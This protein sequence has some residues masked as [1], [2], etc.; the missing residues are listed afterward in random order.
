[1]H[2]TL[3]MI[4]RI[5]CEATDDGIGSDDLYAVI[6][7][8]SIA[9]GSFSAGDRIDLGIEVSIPAG[10]SRMTVMERDF[11]DPDDALATIDLSQDMDVER[12]VGILQ[13]DARYDIWFR[14]ISGGDGIEGGGRC[15]DSCPTCGDPC[16]KD[17]NHG[18][19]V[20]WCGRHE[21]GAN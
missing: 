19:T 17:A 21:W 7:G 4:N 18:G 16:L 9:L 13:G 6:G 5:A 15:P 20:H 2:P 1:M 11:P 3:L 10:A 12:V 14:V 8:Q